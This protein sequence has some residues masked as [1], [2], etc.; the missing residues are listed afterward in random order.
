MVIPLRL[1][2]LLVGNSLT[3]ILRL[4]FVYFDLSTLGHFLC[5]SGDKDQNKVVFLQVRHLVKYGWLRVSP[6]FLIMQAFLSSS[7][8]W[9]LNEMID[10]HVCGWVAWRGVF[11]Y[12]LILSL[13]RFSHW[14]YYRTVHPDG[15]GVAEMRLK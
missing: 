15:N 6:R 11:S 14:M 1:L 7:L 2:L 13:Y 8:V 3:G 10:M 12:P 5:A 9:S 4:P